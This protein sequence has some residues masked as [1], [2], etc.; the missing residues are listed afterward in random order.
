MNAM[1]P[2][3]TASAA[4]PVVTTSAAEREL[5]LTALIDAPR[6]KLYRCWTDAELFKQ[7]I[8]PLPYTTPVAEMDV[9]T[10]G[11]SFFLMKG[12]QGEEISCPGVFLE[13]V[14]N[15]KLVMTDAYTK[16][17]EPSEKPFMTT[18]VT[19]ADEGDGKT[20][21][22]ARCLHWTAET[23][24]AHEDMGFHQGW[25]QVTE[26]LAALAARI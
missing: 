26:Q 1:S 21:Y 20:R 5:T 13:V 7:W 8:A 14:P 11:S 18:I 17:W 3:Q 23:R 22:T 2:A 24:K 12:P 16:A 6:E 15:E 4:K 25:T 10:G 9:R 19:F